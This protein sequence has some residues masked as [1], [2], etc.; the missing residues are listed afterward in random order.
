MAVRRDRQVQGGGIESAWTRPRPIGDIRDL[1]FGAL[2]PDCRA[3]CNASAECT[4]A[5]AS[6]KPPCVLI[7]GPV[8]TQAEAR[9]CSTARAAKRSIRIVGTINAPSSG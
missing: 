9:S 4:M 1:E 7:A 5:T 3:H 8:S 2:K 6:G